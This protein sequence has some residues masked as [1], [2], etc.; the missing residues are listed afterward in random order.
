MQRHDSRLETHPINRCALSLHQVRTIPVR[1][2]LQVVF[3]GAEQLRDQG[4]PAA[5]RDILLGQ[6]LHELQ[7]FLLAH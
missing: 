4:P 7:S 5:N 6:R 1:D 2:D 3:T